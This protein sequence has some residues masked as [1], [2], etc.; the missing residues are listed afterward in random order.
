MRQLLRR[1]LGLKQWHFRPERFLAV[2]PAG[3]YNL[4]NSAAG[5]KKPH[6]SSARLP[7]ISNQLDVP[8]VRSIYIY[9]LQ[10]QGVCCICHVA[11]LSLNCHKKSLVRPI[12]ASR[13]GG[14]G[15]ASWVLQRPLSTPACNNGAQIFARDGRTEDQ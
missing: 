10:L 4:N 7:A 14:G 13:R 3:I 11:D 2:F 8:T 9:I 12:E 6:Q 1:G 15:V 5:H